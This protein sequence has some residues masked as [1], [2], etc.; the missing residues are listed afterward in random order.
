MKLETISIAAMLLVI[1]MMSA[2]P[3]ASAEVV[4]P[5]AVVYAISFEFTDG[6]EQ[7]FGEVPMNKNLVLQDIPTEIGTFHFKTISTLFESNQQLPNQVRV[8]TWR[9]Y[10]EGTPVV[11]FWDPE[12]SN[13]YAGIGT[14]RGLIG[15]PPYGTCVAVEWYH[16]DNPPTDLI[17]RLLDE[18]SMIRTS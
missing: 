17:E 9:Y 3:M 15:S 6:T 7:Y 12:I 14:G 16:S 13:G 1:G 11:V 18:T 10:D 4:E 2:V 8:H 5:N